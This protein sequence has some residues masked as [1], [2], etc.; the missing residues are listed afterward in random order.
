MRLCRTRGRPMRLRTPDCHSWDSATP[1]SA[2]DGTPAS[3]PAP[4]DGAPA[5]LPMSNVAGTT[6]GLRMPD[7]ELSGGLVASF[8]SFKLLANLALR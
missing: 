5:D 6:A 8:V 2:P 7:P 3:A 1:A 4:A